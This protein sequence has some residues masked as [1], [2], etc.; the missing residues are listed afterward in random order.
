MTKMK[1]ITISMDDWLY[2]ELE[3]KREKKGRSEFISEMI[4]K[5]LGFSENGGLSPWL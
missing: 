4:A 3:N 5:G 2:A 1:R